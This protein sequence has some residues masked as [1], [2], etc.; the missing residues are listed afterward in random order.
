MGDGREDIKFAQADGE[1]QKR[2][3]PDQRQKEHLGPC[4]GGEG[5]LCNHR[6]TLAVGRGYCH[7]NVALR[8]EKAAPDL[9]AAFNGSAFAVAYMVKPSFRPKANAVLSSN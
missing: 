4:A 3:A 9:S 2:R 7:P 1:G 6:G 8:T 5:L